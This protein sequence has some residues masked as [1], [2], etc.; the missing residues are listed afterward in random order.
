MPRCSTRCAH[1]YPS[2]R[3]LGLAPDRARELAFRTELG[4]YFERVL[5]AKGQTHN[6]GV[7]ANWIPQLVERIGSDGDPAESQVSPEAL[8]AVRQ[9]VAAEEGRRDAARD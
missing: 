2:F 5:A 6:P 1:G 4:D 3:Q 9:M 7:V 8:A